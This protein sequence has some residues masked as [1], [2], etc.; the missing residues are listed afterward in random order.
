MNMSDSEQQTPL[1]PLALPDYIFF[2]D[3]TEITA[4]GP[5]QPVTAAW[6]NPARSHARAPRAT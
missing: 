5:F 4:C 6:M 2:A 3:Q 1:I